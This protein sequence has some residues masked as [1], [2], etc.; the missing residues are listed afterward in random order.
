MAH[1]KK[2]G[3]ALGSGGPK[4]IAHIGVLKVLIENEIPL[5]FISGSS[6]G[7]LVG[8]HYAAFKNINE[9]ERFPLSQTWKDG[10]NVFDPGIKGGFVKGNKILNLLNREFGELTFNDTLIPLS[11]IAVDL[12]TGERIILEKGELTPAIRASISVPI[13]FKPIKHQGRLLVDGGV[14]DPVPAKALRARGADVVIGVNLDNKN[15]TYT[16][17]E[18][19]L[20]IPRAAL[21]SFLIMQHYL[22]EKSHH[23]ADLVIS[24]AVEQFGLTGWKN[25]FNPEKA[26]DLIDKGERAAR[27]ALPKIKK[28]L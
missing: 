22:A 28:L 18:K 11:I 8:S 12:N 1:R 3:L 7:A 13:I 16:L 21:R 9:L 27:Q 24:P 20:S 17:T 10:F 19:N 6:I 15:F 26:I 4:G 2:I 5:D 23:E 14:A 25:F